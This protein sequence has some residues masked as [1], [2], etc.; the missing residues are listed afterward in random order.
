MSTQTNNGVKT[1]IVKSEI[2][3]DKIYAAEFQKEGTLTAQ[4]RQIVTT[5]S[6]YP[7]KKVVNN[8]QG[9][10]FDNEEFGFEAQ[11]F[12][13][14]EQRVAWIPVPVNASA[15]SIAAKLAKANA[16]KAVIY[17]ALSNEPIL[18]E[19]QL[20]AI[21]VGL[22]TKD[23]FANSQAV[24]Y[25]AG[26]EKDGVDVSG[27]LTLDKAGK[28]QYRRTFF[29]NGAQPDVDVRDASKEGYLSP[30]LKAELAGASVMQGQTL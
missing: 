12:E 27:K 19:D 15:E 30:E 4:I 18:T 28:V 9:G 11:E 23:Q 2:T 21:K 3:L 10:I 16:N 14:Q 17:R 26:T 25:P 6:S 1:E 13:S 29:W 24:R 22:A 8:M 7:S 20:Y 5:K